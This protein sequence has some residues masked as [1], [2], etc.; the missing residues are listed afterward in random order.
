VTIIPIR[1]FGD[2][3]LRQP[4]APVERFDE[5]LR[6]LADDMFD[7]MYDAPGVGLAAPQVGLSM[8]FF[9]FDAGEGREK[10][11]VANPI[12]SELDGDQEA[13]EG[14]LSV[15]GLYYPTTRANHVRLD[16]QDLDGSRITLIGDE[17]LARIFQHETDH[18][19]GMLYLDRLSKAD[20]RQAM[21]DI[22]ELELTGHPTEGRAG[23]SA[24]P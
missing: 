11:V 12:L 19:D 24:R 3:V 4:G 22:R 21:A 16:G 15:P 6:R 10:G 17:L 8:R 9:V 13:E 7:T 5:A 23:P 1:T 20:R 18:L 14:C 2:P